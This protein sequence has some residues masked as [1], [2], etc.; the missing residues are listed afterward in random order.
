MERTVI[1]ATYDQIIDK[2]LVIYT[3]PLT[4]ISEEIKQL[5]VF[6]Y[7]IELDINMVC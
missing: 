2:K 1:F 4:I 6:Q 5:E 7:S 3:C